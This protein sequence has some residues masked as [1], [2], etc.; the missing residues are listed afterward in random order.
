MVLSTFFVC[1]IS[2]QQFSTGRGA[3]N[4]ISGTWQDIILSVSNGYQKAW[5]TSS[6][7]I[8]TTCHDYTLFL[9]GNR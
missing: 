2:I 6:Q 5:I 8:K 4:L 3:K 1:N 9:K 7:K